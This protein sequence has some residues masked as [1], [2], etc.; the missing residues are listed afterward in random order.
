[1][2][3]LGVSMGWIKEMTNAQA[4]APR[5][6]PAIKNP[7]LLLTAELDSL[8][9]PDGHETF[10]KQVPNSSRVL[11]KGSF[12]EPLFEVDS[13]RKPALS[14]C[15]K[16]LKRDTNFEFDLRYP[17]VLMNRFEDKEDKGGWSKTKVLLSTMA[18][19]VAARVVIGVARRR[20]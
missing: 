2:A 7:V 3:M 4:R 18:V 5:I 20:E 12:H 9:R 19:L 15:L 8:V 14:A 10:V 1:M 6:M 13:I 16:W 17:L 11:V